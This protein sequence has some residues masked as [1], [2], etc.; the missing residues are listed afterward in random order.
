MNRP[1]TSYPCLRSRYA[2]TELSTP[3][4]MAKT[5][6]AI[7]ASPPCRPCF[8]DTTAAP[9]VLASRPGRRQVPQ[10]HREV[11][12]RHGPLAVSRE[13][14]CQHRRRVPL[15]AAHFLPSF[16]VPEPHPRVGAHQQGPV[17]LRVEYPP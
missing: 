15:D 12:R 8:S 17:A 9:E 10:P 2:D 11:A 7:L 4:L 16:Q 13:R 3:P 14:Q 6:R 5:T 1:M